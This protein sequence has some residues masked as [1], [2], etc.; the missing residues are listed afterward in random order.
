ML[1]DIV[2]DLAEYGITIG[3]AH[4]TPAPAAAA[5][6]LAKAQGKLSTH[7]Q[8]NAAGMDRNEKRRL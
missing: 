6:A 4:V 1:V 7:E 8:L 2:E 3:K 5:H